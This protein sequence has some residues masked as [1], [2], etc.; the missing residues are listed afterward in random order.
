MSNPDQAAEII[1]DW[2]QRHKNQFDRDPDWAAHGLA[3]ELYNEGLIAP[4]LPEPDVRD[5]IDWWTRLA[6]VL[7]NEDG[8]QISIIFDNHW[9]DAP[10]PG[11]VR[12]LGLA[13]LAA[14]NY[15]E[16]A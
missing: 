2:Q 12:E 5:T 13:L 9:V 14:A 3:I 4:E 10:S 1:R 7:L 8:E 16:E 6:S 15:Q 11:H